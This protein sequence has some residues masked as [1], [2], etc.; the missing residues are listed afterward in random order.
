MPCYNNADLLYN[1]LQGYSLQTFPKSHFELIIVDNNSQDPNI[2][3]CYNKFKN[4]LTVTLLF[5]HLLPDPFA[6]NSARNLGVNIAKYD[7]CIFTDSD[8]IPSPST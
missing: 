3:S 5:R 7:W 8:C 6:L 4:Q 1:L 2:I